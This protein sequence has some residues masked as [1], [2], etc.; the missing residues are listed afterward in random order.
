MRHAIAGV[1]HSRQMLE[2]LGAGSGIALKSC[3]FNEFSMSSGSRC[4]S[5]TGAGLGNP[6]TQQQP[7]A[8]Y[9]SAKPGR[10]API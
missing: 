2:R 1:T 9:L 5:N 4:A 6:R 8:H 10:S 7:R 3:F